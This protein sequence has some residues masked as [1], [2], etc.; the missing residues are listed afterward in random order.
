[1]TAQ[2]VPSTINFSSDITF[3]KTSPKF[4]PPNSFC[5]L[6][7]LLQYFNNINLNNIRPPTNILISL[8]VCPTVCKKTGE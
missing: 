5:I 3:R 4:I 6:L 2:D 8:N 7:L 1:M